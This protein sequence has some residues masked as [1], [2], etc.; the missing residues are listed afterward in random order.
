[1]RIA[2]EIEADIT[3]LRLVGRQVHRPNAM[4]GHS[5]P[6]PEEYYRINVAIP[7]IDH[8]EA[9][10]TTTFNAVLVVKYLG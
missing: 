4:P 3:V 2:D 6:G 7:F 9:E 10:L 8:L 1:M 5:T